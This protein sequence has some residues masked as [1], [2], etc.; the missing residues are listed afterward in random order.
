MFVTRR[1]CELYRWPDHPS[2]PGRVLV[3]TY[4]R[5]LIVL[6]A[7]RRLEGLGQTKDPVIES[8]SASYF[9]HGS[10]TE[11]SMAQRLAAPEGGLS[12]KESSL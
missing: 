12:S 4:V 2:T 9:R 10:Q 3:L 6:G 5:G 1:G 11:D 8:V 7:T